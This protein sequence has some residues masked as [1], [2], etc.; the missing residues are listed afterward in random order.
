MVH[1]EG[2]PGGFRVDNHERLFQDW[3]KVLAALGQPLDGGPWKNLYFTAA[4]HLLP[5]DGVTLPQRTATTFLYQPVL[6]FDIDHCDVTRAL[7]YGACVAQVLKVKPE[8]LIVN[9]TGNGV[10]T[11]LH[12]KTPIRSVKY[13]KELKPAYNELCHQIEKAIEKAGLP[14][15][16]AIGGKVDTVIFDP[17]RVLRVPGTVNSKPSKSDPKV[18]ENKE[19]VCVQYSG[20]FHEID[21]MNLSGLDKIQK[22]NIS[23]EQVK[24][25]YPTPDFQEI[26]KE[27]RFVKWTMESS[28]EAHEPQ[29]FDLFSLLAVQPP[30]AKVSYQGREQT[31]RELAESVF[32]GAVNSKSAAAQDFDAKWEQAGR[33]G[34]RKCS[35]ISS[36][37]IGGCETC[38]HN[39][40]I[41][42]PLALKSPAFV[43]SEANGYWVL[44][45]KGVQ[46]HPH[47]GDLAKVY[48]REH[49]YVTR[50]KE[51]LF[52]FQEN[53]YKETP[54]L[55]VKSWFD[56]KLVPDDP[57][58]ETHRI[59]FIKRVEVCGALSTDAEY[60][61][62]NQSTLGR[63]NCRN[64]VL[65]ILKGTLAPHSPTFGFQYVLPYDYV[66]N[67]SSELFLEW[68]STVTQNRTELMDSLLDIMAYSL[69]PNYD[70]H[71]FV[72]LVGEGAN[73]KSTLLHI[74]QALVGKNNYSA[75]SMQQLG[76]NR[77]AP[78][79]LEGKLVNLSEES[80]GY[81]LNID[82]LNVI[83]NLSSGGEMQI[84]RKGVQPITFQNKA[85]LIFS[86]NKPPRFKE[87]GF[88]IERR[89]VVIPF[90]FTITA[91]DPRIETRLI[92]DV[93]KIMSMLI[94]RIQA[95]IKL[96]GGRFL[97]FRG[98]EA[99][100][101]ARDKIL[102][103]GNTVVEWANERLE[104]S[105]EFT[106]DQYVGVKDS[107]EDYL[108][109]CKKS[110]FERPVNIRQFGHALSSSVLI[111]AECR[112]VI[113]V[114]GK[115]T[116]IFTQAKWKEEE[117]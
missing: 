75:I 45:P 103:S 46:M 62:F 83:K 13:L 44:N 81:D 21:L 86:A 25:Q 54:S 108:S 82:E 85:K 110:N 34:A 41:P 56:K 67:E 40:K 29:L 97:V 20:T 114:A 58:R 32:N 73:G 39:A 71:M 48:S 12:L 70:D 2:H 60:H 112:K 68:L 116:K 101:R 59:E 94:R 1:P 31:P 15:N 66:E 3:P 98:G 19:A 117:L 74:I 50:F 76:G 87:T 107:F 61:L 10:Q 4:H 24:R 23:P 7:E 30:G 16:R 115:C 109:W 95:N 65:D 79:N 92:E 106:Q 91:P 11:L 102:L 111:S 43:G 26:V 35:T 51:R 36:N 8:S 9:V 96:N 72:Y 55:S 28:D 104:V 77:F 42:T 53:I 38:P 93:P 64:G 80:S 78:A 89:M 37:W 88:A 105:P 69:W 47:Y 100:A 90:D 33:Y 49:S 113:R 63:L 27:C 52:S 22:E 5:E 6:A 17:G 99:A 84:E 57:I 18:Y 14:L